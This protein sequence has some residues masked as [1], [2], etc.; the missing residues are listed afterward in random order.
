MMPSSPVVSLSSDTI[1]QVCRENATGPDLM[2]LWSSWQ[3]TVESEIWPYNSVEPWLVNFIN[4]C[5]VIALAAY[6]NVCLQMHF[7][8]CRSILVAFSCEAVS[9]GVRAVKIFRQ[10]LSVLN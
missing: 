4:R 1:N 10:N 5:L 9:N 2:D 3:H 7:F 6:R 8:K